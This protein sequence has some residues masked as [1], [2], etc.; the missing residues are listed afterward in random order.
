[1][2][3][4][5][6]SSRLSRFSFLGVAL[7][8]GISTLPTSARASVLMTVTES[9]GNVNVIGSGTLNLTALSFIST[10]SAN[11]G[12]NGSIAVLRVGPGGGLTDRYSGFTG[13]TS[14]GTLG[15]FTTATSGTGDRFGV[16]GSLALIRIEVP[17]GYASG[18]ALSGSLLFT[19]QTF[20]SLGLTPGT[21]TWNWGSGG[22]ADSLTV[23]VGAAAP[24]PGTLALLALGVVGG[25]VARRR[26]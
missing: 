12:I 8:L 24:E 21:Y 15:G 23:Q 17:V 10:A 1:M 6:F 25:I 9:G 14:F 5:V 2:N 19:G 11:I 13:P 22:T 18:G 26:K 3:P 16:V 4:S 20:A 7:F